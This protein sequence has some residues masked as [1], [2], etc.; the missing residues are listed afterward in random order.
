VLTEK[1][2]I[3]KTNGNTDIWKELGT[4]THMKNW[5]LTSKNVNTTLIEWS[6]HSY[7]KKL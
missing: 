4:L 7:Q 3:Q 2:C 6:M 5:Q 1:F